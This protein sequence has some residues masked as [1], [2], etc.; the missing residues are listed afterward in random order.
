MQTLAFKIVC[1]SIALLAAALLGTA[2]AEVTIVNTSGGFLGS[3]K[4][5]ITT[6]HNGTEQ[7]SYDATGVDKLV[8]TLG[9]ESSFSNNQVTNLQV[10]FNGV[11]MT[12]AVFGN[13]RGSLTNDCGAAA[14]FYLDKPFQG[15]AAFSV[16]FAA[17]NG[18]ANGGRVAIV[19]LAGTED[20]V[21]N[22]NAS[23]ATQASAGIVSTSL[24]TSAQNSLVIAMVQNSGTNNSAGTPTVVAPL[25]LINNGFWG[26]QWGSAASGHQFVP[27]PG[28]TVSPT[29]NT[30]AGGNIQILAAEFYAPS[31]DIPTK[32]SPAYGGIVPGGDVG[33]SWTNLAPH[34]GENVWVDVW[35]GSNPNALVKVVGAASD[36]PNRSTAM[37][38]APAAGTW[39][40]RVD[41]YVGG[42]PTG[43]T[44]TGT[45]NFFTVEDGDN[46]GI[47]DSWEISYFG[48]LV[49]AGDDPD[50]DGLTNLREYQMGLNPTD[51]DTDGDGL[52]DG[53]S[54]SVSS[55]DA[56][57]A[58]WVNQ[59]ILFT[60]NGNERIFRGENEMGTDPLNR[61]TDGD[62]L[63]DGVE[64]KTGIWL[65]S[66]DTGTDP[67]NPDTD[68]DGLRDGVETNTGVFVSAS[69]S[70]TSPLLTDT[71]GDGAN[72]WYEVVVSNTN[73]LDPNDKPFAPY[74][75]PQ[76]DP[77]D[78]G[79]GNKPVKVFILSGQ[80]NMVGFG[81]VDGTAAGTLQR[82]SK[83]ENKFPNLVDQDTGGWA[84]RNDVRY[85]GVGQTP[86]KAPLAPGFGTNTN[87]F[88]PELGFGH[89]M[90][91]YHDEPVLLIKAAV[92]GRALG[93]DYLP[94]G[95]TQFTLGAT[96]YAGY[97]D[98]PASWAAGS[99]PAPGT[100]QFYGGYQFDQ[101]F[102]RFAD[103][104]PTGTTAANINT[105]R[106]L[107]QFTTEYPEW[108]G[109]GF[110]IAG[111]VWWQGWNDGLSNNTAYAN[112][113]EQNMVRFIKEIRSYYESI[114]PENIAPNAPFVLATAGFQGFTNTVANRATVVNAQFAVDGNAGK[115]P[116]FEGNVRTID[117][118]PF[119]RNASVSPQNEEFHYHHN[120]ETYMIVGDLLGRAMAEL[121][122][123]ELPVGN[124][125]DDW[126]ALFSGIDLSDPNADFNHDG[127]TNNEK[128]I[129]GLDPTSGSSVNPISV[130]LEARSGSFSYTRRSPSLTGIT[131]RYEWTST[132][133]AE[134]WQAFTPAQLTSDAGTPVETV[135]VT[136][137]AAL[138]ENSRLFV[139]V[140]A[141]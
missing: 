82:F 141:E 31:T 51:P 89:V 66:S 3:T 102:K 26:S 12:R 11:P 5:Q 79:T 111:F 50:M 133:D 32:P 126:A 113:Y 44:V 48:G 16:T 117:S 74:P 8:V 68:G 75:L 139:R 124:D 61:D 52:L 70:G 36:N 54:I 91:W 43:E 56:R 127:L 137:P 90:G 120:A 138:L 86:G 131:Y 87:S 18:A 37:V 80:S 35:F 98:A 20:G 84:A 1:R 76:V 112:R 15:S 132:L 6:S 128:R 135:E 81:R 121:L 101:S 110:E 42:E 2:S 28:T 83:E 92:G 25:S 23:G 65:S 69:N 39:Y 106:I 114:Y 85:R 46:D 17:T 9:A 78:S 49:N 73:P 109:R 119:W 4:S 105:A 63:L 47:P 134:S 45:V 72:D 123:G 115:Y 27:A 97:G 107:D 64:T 40:W 30:A 19:G 34:L 22:T 57:Y 129:W 93:W 55:G 116:E 104:H 118:R 29:F 100:A 41:S 95:S 125:Y 94:P 99:P 24:T 53:D 7:V 88:G 130:Q 103:W 62:G 38:N 59:G 58:G 122:E 60:Q 96:T 108:A 77:G 14:I 136:V 67:L 71:D 21:G 33:L 10:S 13:T 140:V